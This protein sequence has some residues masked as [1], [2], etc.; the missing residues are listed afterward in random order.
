MLRKDIA[1]MVRMDVT[2]ANQF[3]E[4]LEEWDKYLELHVS[5]YKDHPDTPDLEPEI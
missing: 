5:Y 1:E 2:S 3:Y 4:A